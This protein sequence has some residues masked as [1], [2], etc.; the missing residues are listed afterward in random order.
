MRGPTAHPA[1]PRVPLVATFMVLLAVIATT[2]QQGLADTRGLT[3]KGVL[4]APAVRLPG[5]S[6]TKE[7]RVAVGPQGDRYVVGS[8]DVRG[9]APFTLPGPLSP[10]DCCF[11]VVF[12]AAPNSNTWSPT[13]GLMAG[14]APNATASNDVDLIVTPTGRL[15]GTM[16]DSFNGIHTSYSDDGGARWTE[17]VAGLGPDTDR[18]WLAYGPADPST[19]EP[20]VYLLFHNGYSGA[21]SHNEYVQKSVDNGASFGPP[22]P[23][24]LPGDPAYSDLQCLDSGGPSGIAVNQS[25]G[26]VYISFGTQSAA[27]GGGC[28]AQG[29][30]PHLNVVPPSRVWVATSSSDTL[31]SWHTSLAVDR[32]GTVVGMQ[33]A[34]PA[35]DAAGTVYVV[36]P[37]S[38]ST[39]DLVASVEYVHATADLT[40][41]SKPVTVAT[42]GAGHLL[43]HIVAG[44]SG[45]VAFAYLSAVSTPRGATV[46]Y[47]TL[48]ET[49]NATAAHPALTESRIATIPSYEGSPARLLGECNATPAGSATDGFLCDRAADDFGIARDAL[50][51]VIVTWPSGVSPYAGAYVSAQTA[52]P[53]L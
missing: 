44:R 3:P 2:Q 38:R 6:Q 12:H 36:Y 46:W 34:P 15:I 25:N 40:D 51:R 52:G 48:A 33:F 13:R 31:G 24:T 35:V 9:S 30:S 41:W 17:V 16:L 21:A 20:T 53:R 47:P 1:T 19:H 10:S 23:V 7:P 14:Q 8:A 50:G 18:P 28:A 29:A 27:V 26:R 42:A 11:A 4:F 5:T 22:V 43:T 39:K 45:R 32:P 37:H 49:F